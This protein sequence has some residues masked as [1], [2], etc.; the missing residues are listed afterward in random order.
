MTT[1][2]RRRS[3]ITGTLAAVAMAAALTPLVPAEADGGLGPAPGAD[4]ADSVRAEVRGGRVRNVLL[5]VG[6]GMGD[7][8]ITL[9]RNYQHG[10]GG[11]LT[12]D[13]LP[14]TGSLTTHSVVKGD[15]GHPEYVTDSA[16]G[17]TAWAIGAKT[18]NGAI[19]VDA[20]GTPRPTLLELAKR[21]GFRTG[22]VTT[23]ELQD[24]TPA[25]IS[26]HVLDRSC[27]GPETMRQCAPNARE[28]GGPG[29]IAEQ[30][31]AL[32]ADVMM[33]G[34]AKYFDQ[35][36]AAGRFA[37]RT[38]R[39][40]AVDTGFQVVERA[41]QLPTLRGD[42]PVLGLFAAEG[43]DSVW[44]GPQ[45]RAGGT[46]PTRCAE[47]TGRDAR[48]PRLAQMTRAA[49][50][51][52]DRR[53]R[54]HDRG[55]FLQVEGAQI[56]WGAHDGLPCEQIGETVQFD[57]AVAVGM[58]FAR[59]HGDTLVIV[60]ADHAQSTQIIPNGVPSPGMTATLVTNEGGHM[61][62]NYATAMPG[63]AQEHTGA[64]VR[65]AGYGPQAANIVGLND[66]TDLFHIL[67]RAMGVH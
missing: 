20:H 8:E 24:A 9:A 22:S 60:T 59:R 26:A 53:S 29:S 15:P 43:L 3:R 64:Q 13:R 56:D 40:Q 16:A 2:Q 57:E 23:S 18:Y 28:N 51:L 66:N 17:A 36:I 21:R 25:A 67:T 12:L 19:G 6:D 41:D 44:T 4:R 27:M 1:S 37:G 58:E 11:R 10:A 55:F 30:Q 62:V 52:L 45:A 63:E 48:Q 31:V 54:G 42:Q 65:V 32:R 7:S 39:Q 46:P 47:N 5:F 49:I 14:L 35:R 61:T 50:D 38:V 33:G 34:G